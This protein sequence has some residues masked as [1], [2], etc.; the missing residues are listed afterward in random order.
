MIHPQLANVGKGNN[1]LSY[2]FLLAYNE[3]RRAQFGNAAIV[4]ATTLLLLHGGMT[5][6][7]FTKGQVNVRHKLAPHSPKNKT[8]Y[9]VWSIDGL[10]SLAEGMKY[11]SIEELMHKVLTNDWAIYFADKL[12]DYSFNEFEKNKAY[13]RVTSIDLIYLGPINLGP[14]VD[15]K[16]IKSLRVYGTHHAQ[17]KNYTTKNN[18]Y[19]N[20]VFPKLYINDSEVG[21]KCTAFDF[22]KHTG[23]GFKSGSSGGRKQMEVS[24]NVIYPLLAKYRKT[25]LPQ[26]MQFSSEAKKSDFTA[27]VVLK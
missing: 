27:K 6:P 2:Q 24:K 5:P 3:V 7:G 16:A 13:K 4:F 15:P 9:N 18:L 26:E 12:F 11:D 1:P 14:G 10:G 25:G 17:D 19:K 20:E 23:Y 22:A 21:V 8:L